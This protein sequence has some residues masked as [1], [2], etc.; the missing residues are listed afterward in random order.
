[1]AE[2]WEPPSTLNGWGISK[3][4]FNKILGTVRT[5]NDSLVKAKIRV[6][7]SNIHYCLFC[8]KKHGLEIN[9]I[10]TNKFFDGLFTIGATLIPASSK[11]QGDT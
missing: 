11:T 2:I 10:R 4:K 1:M 9:C 5:A 3:L 8:F 7:K 6:K